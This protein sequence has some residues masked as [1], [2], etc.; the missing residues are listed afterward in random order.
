M[1]EY[2][3]LGDAVESKKILTTENFFM[4]MLVRVPINGGQSVLHCGGQR[5]L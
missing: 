3:L 2:V 1:I 5:M 4:A